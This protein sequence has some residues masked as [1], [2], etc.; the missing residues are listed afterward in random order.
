[1]AR[2]PLKFACK[3]ISLAHPV[4]LMPPGL[5]P[6][7]QNV[8]VTSQGNLD[9][10][11]SITAIE[12]TDVGPVHSLRRLNNSVDST[13]TRLAGVASKLYSDGN[14]ID[15]GYSG[16]PLSLVPFRP[17]LSPNPYMYIGDSQRMRKVD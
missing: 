9:V 12:S 11:Q 8:R 5:F 13:Y 3:G 15:S 6:I 7:L 2:P 1:M 10:R 17:N 4:D 16:N 14:P